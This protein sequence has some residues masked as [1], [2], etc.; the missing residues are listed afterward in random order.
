MK[1][2]KVKNKSHYLVLI[3]CLFLVLGIVI[4]F[5]IN[6]IGSENLG[7]N[8][9]IN[10]SITL[11]KKDIYKYDNVKIFKGE[12]P[13]FTPEYRIENSTPFSKEVIT[14]MNNIPFGKT[15]TYNDIAKT[16]AKKRKISKMSAQAVGGAVGKNPICIIVPCHR[17]VGKNGNFFYYYSFVK[18]IFCSIYFLIWLVSFAC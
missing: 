16:I 9:D 6:L 10:D 13:D 12:N 2:V 14:I 15:I 17:V 4:Y 11:N 3:C 1:K 8:N 7:N 5:I 18:W